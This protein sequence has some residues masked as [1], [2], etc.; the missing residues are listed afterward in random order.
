[1]IT[2]ITGKIRKVAGDELIL[3]VG[4]FEYQV[5]IPEFTRRQLQSRIGEELSLH[6]IEYLDGN[7]AHGRLTP[8]LVGFVNELE[9]EFFDMFCSV[10][11]VGS[12][13]ALRAMVRPVAEVADSI[14]QQDTK[15]L[16]A[17]PG[18]GPATAERI[19]AK[20]RRKVPKFAL[21]I[22]SD[23]PA[24]AE[25][26]RDVVADT[27]DVLRSLGHSEPDARRLIDAALAQKKKYKDVETLLHAV[28]QQNAAG[29]A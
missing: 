3:A 9:R 10:D 11:G 18:I 13:K 23:V 14:E 25:V 28:Y 1:M 5:L 16:S 4:A 15:A 17:L 26:S 2:K 6:T 27:F 7:P 20:L 8:R 22:S 19:V 12:R 21:L 29:K 24:E